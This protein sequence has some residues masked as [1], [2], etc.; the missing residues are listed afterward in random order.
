MWKC[1]KLKNVSSKMLD[2]KCKF[3]NVSTKKLVRKSLFQ[4][5]CSKKF[6]LKNAQIIIKAYNIEI[7]WITGITVSWKLFEKMY[8]FK[9]CH[10]IFWSARPLKFEK[11]FSLT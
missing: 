3:E 9:K 5:I 6:I 11:S 10:S 8:H 7:Y 2:H 4:K 1:E